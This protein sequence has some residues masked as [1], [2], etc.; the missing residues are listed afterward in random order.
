MGAMGASQII[1][2]RI[3]GVF[4]LTEYSLFSIFY[5]IVCAMNRGCIHFIPRNL[6]FWCFSIHSS[7]NFFLFHLHISCDLYIF[8]KIIWN[9]LQ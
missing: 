1:A 3:S 9:A 7:H 8:I 4:L 5:C 6:I 2:Q